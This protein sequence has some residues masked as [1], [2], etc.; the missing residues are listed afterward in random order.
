MGLMSNYRVNNILDAINNELKTVAESEELSFSKRDLSKRINCSE[1]TIERLF[2]DKLGCSFT[3]YFPRLRIEYA[4]QLLLSTPLPIADI[5]RRVG[6]TPSAFSKEFKK[7]FPNT[8]P[9]KFRKEESRG[10][11]DYNMR[12]YEVVELPEMHFIYNSH[13][14]S[15]LALESIEKEKVLFDSLIEIASSEG[16]LKLPL[17]SYG[18]AFDDE[19][20]RESAD[21]RYYACIEVMKPIKASYKE[22]NCITISS[23]KY[24]KFVHRGSY[25]RLDL[26]YKEV[27][28]NMFFNS[29]ES[30]VWDDRRYILEHYIST[31]KYTNE[32]D[33]LTEVLFPMR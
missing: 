10:L 24:A 9:A 32:E 30:F 27:F 17:E 25:A 23:C 2:N 16:V 6:Y 5:A 33:L 14:G 15:Y 28:Y 21:C 8:T 31:V 1:R 11:R 26:L 19:G 13:I 7:H 3:K 22:I 20:V 18:I 4:V 29:D 12:N